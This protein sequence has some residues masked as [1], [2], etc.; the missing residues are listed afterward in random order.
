MLKKILSGLAL[1]VVVFLI[2]VSLMPSHYLIKRDILISAKPEAIFP[3]LVSMKKADQW[4]PWK[5]ADPEVKNTYEGPD[6]GL[7]A[8]SRWESNG[9]MGFGQAEV[10]EVI[11]NQRVKTKISYT[12][13]MQFTQESEFNLTAGTEGVVMTWTASGESPFVNRLICALGIMNMDKYV[14]GEFE[15]GLKK[16]KILSEASTK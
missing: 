11:E 4:M 1:A 13:P 5:D 2:Y 16:L 9:R 7:G 10:V 14:G 12:K 8:I 6:S 15:K 3:Y